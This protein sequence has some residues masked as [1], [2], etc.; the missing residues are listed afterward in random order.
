MLPSTV[1]SSFPLAKIHSKGE[2]GDDGLY[3]DAVYMFDRSQGGND[4][5]RGGKGDDGLYGD[6]VFMYDSSKG[7]KDILIGAD[8]T[9]AQPGKGEVDELTGGKNGDRFVLGD[10]SHVYYQGGGN[11]D[12]ARILD[13]ST[14]ERDLIQLKGDLSD[15]TLG[16]TNG[17]TTIAFNQA[18]PD[19]VGIVQGV[20][21]TSK[22]NA[23]TFV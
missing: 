7:G 18:T 6:A 10:A 19:L 5:L 2:K 12:Y 1:P 23:F 13:F 8:S 17:N 9:A 3:G 14:T 22:P 20:D 15:Y 11:I 21:L 16:F 4:T